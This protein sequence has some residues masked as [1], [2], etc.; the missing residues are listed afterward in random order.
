M[1]ALAPLGRTVWTYPSP[2]SI[3]QPPLTSPSGLPPLLW[4]E[5]VPGVKR[6]FATNQPVI[7]LTFDACGSPGDGVNTALLSMLERERVP[8]TLFLSGRWIDKFPT[9]AQALARNP[10]FTIGNHGQ[11]HRPASL[12]G[13]SVYGLPGTGSLAEFQAEFDSNARKI[14]R[15]TGTYP[16]LCR[17]GGAYWDTD[18]VAALNQMGSQA[19]GFSVLGDRGA[20]YNRSQ[21]AQAIASARPGDIVVLHMNHPEKDT[22]AGV[23]MGIQAL[24]QRG[25]G[26]TQ[27]SPTITWQP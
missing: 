16:R 12:Y 26:F 23:E 5:H 20:T 10:L 17:S 14:Q 25:I 19:I 8:A 21:I 1:A 13:A 4:G 11:N 2:T 18:A 27:L 3:S 22:A 7:A 24:K 6:R 15:L 9:V